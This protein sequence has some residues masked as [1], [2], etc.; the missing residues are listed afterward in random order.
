MNFFE[1]QDVARRKTGRLVVLFVLAVIVIVGLTYLVI[2]GALVF[3]GAVG[4]SGSASSLS[5]VTHP[6]LL[7]GVGSVTILIIGLGSLT[8]L[9][10]LRGGGAVVAESVGGRL[11]V[12]GSADRVERRL[13]NVV[14][15]MAIASGVGVPPVYILDEQGI[16][17]FA[18]GFLLP[19]HGGHYTERASS[20]ST[21]GRAGSSPGR[22]QCVQTQSRSRTPP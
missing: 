20:A 2:A 10:Q 9:A 11:L 16:N 14:E 13:L 12:P 7:L 21:L 19:E 17:A 4:E 5:R 1:S 22:T 8:K 6:A 18:A 3:S 15:E